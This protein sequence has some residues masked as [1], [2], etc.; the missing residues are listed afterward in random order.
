MNIFAHTYSLADVA[1]YCAKK[2]DITQYNVNIHISE[3]C[4]KHDQALGWCYD[5]DG[6]ELDVEIEQSLSA[7]DKILTLCHEMVHARQAIRG[8]KAFCEDEANKLEKE[9]YEQYKT[10]E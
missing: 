8:D 2:L 1:K 5:L 9:L 6:N 7:D 4:L 3:C 10:N